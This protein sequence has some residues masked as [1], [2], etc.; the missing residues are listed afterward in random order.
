MASPYDKL[1]KWLQL[2]LQALI[3]Y[4]I[5]TCVLETMPE[6]EGYK[7]FFAI[8]EIVVVALF[9]I[10]YLALWAL[11]DRRWRHPFTPMAVIDLLAILP[12]YVGLTADWRMLRAVRLL[13]LFR[14]LKLGRSRR[15]LQILGTAI[16][17]A[18][19]EFA[20]FGFVA[21][22]IVL[23]AATGIYYA[24]HDAQPEVY[25][26]IPA[27]CWWA[28]VTLTTVGYGDAYPVTP[29][30]CVMAS[31]VMFTGIGFVA[32]PTGIITSTMTDLLREER[33]QRKAA[34]Q[35]KQGSEAEEL[36]NVK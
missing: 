30:G 1:P 19:P 7:Q 14:I 20:A 18:A 36:P 13:R 5:V 11:A 15:S 32:I 23:I 28:V 16:N 25:S 3:V 17:R 2:A 33:E 27:S 26:S 24:E 4:S 6:L 10:E 8:S 22:V 29:V 21:V 9:T 34:L 31:I 35:A 12:F